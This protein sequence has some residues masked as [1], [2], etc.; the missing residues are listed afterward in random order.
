MPKRPPKVETRPR[1]LREAM[2]Q[3]VHRRLVASGSLLL[4]AA[5]AMLE[6]YVEMLLGLFRPLGRLFSTEQIEHLRNILAQKLDEAYKKSPYSRIHIEYETNPSPAVSISYVI[7]VRHSTM[8]MEYEEWTHDRKPPL[9]GKHPDA[10]VLAL[11]ASLGAPAEVPVLDIGA[12]TG[13][14]TLPLARAG[15]PTSAVEAS[16]ALSKILETSAA[17]EGLAVEIFAGNVLEA[18]LPFPAGR[19]KLIILCEV[20]IHVRALS[21]LRALFRRASELLAPGGLLCFSTFVSDDA[22]TPDRLTRELAEV[23]WSTVQ[24]RAELR[25]VMQDLPFKA[26]SDESVFAY[27]KEHLPP[28]AWPPTGWF[29]EW[30][31]G[32]DVFDLSEDNAPLEL[33]WLVFERV[34]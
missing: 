9:F 34:A 19:F 32:I 16:P 18:A 13:R 27:E 2:M 10:K 30:T 8:A 29:G 15:Y 33:R 6:T 24:T 4:P 23:F 31:R 12:G 17:D 11:A 22:Y 21:D 3:R 14:N 5:P 1:V 7:S 26:V 20:L 28:E 25:T